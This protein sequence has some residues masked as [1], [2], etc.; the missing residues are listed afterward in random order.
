MQGTR[1]APEGI[2]S[3]IGEWIRRDYL[4]TTT[5]YEWLYGCRDNAFLQIRYKTLISEAAKAVG[6]KNFTTLWREYLKMQM[7]KGG[8]IIESSTDFE[9]QEMELRCGE[10]TCD[11]FGVTVFNAYGTEQMVCSHPIQMQ[12]KDKHSMLTTLREEY[13]DPALRIAGDRILW[14][15]R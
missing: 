9:G 6:V 15:D 1:D 10:Y 3:I 11:D 12:F 5:P 7:Q 4:E 2:P 14:A 8:K 13:P